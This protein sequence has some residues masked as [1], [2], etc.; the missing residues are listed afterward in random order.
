M[1]SVD[2]AVMYR[3][4]EGG[5]GEVF[6]SYADDA[7]T[8][9]KRRRCKDIRPKKLSVK[10]RKGNASLPFMGGGILLDSVIKE[11]HS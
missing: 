10:P 5:C 3:A 9:Y 6:A 7:D 2:G 1:N 8:E 4:I 11:V